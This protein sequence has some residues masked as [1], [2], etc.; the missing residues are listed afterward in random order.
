MKTLISEIAARCE[1]RHNC[2]MAGNKEW[3][4]K[5]EAILKNLAEYLPH[6]SGFDSGTKID[7]DGSGA[8]KVILETSFHHMDENGMYSG[9]TEHVVTVR[10][11]LAHGFSLKIGGRDRNDIKDYIAQCLNDCLESDLWFVDREFTKL[12]EAR[13]EFALSSTWDKDGCRQTW[14][15]KGQAF[16]T[17]ESAK[18]WAIAQ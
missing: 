15:C 1:Q 2:I 12:C 5:S 9:W 7:M 3:Q 16:E 4:E 14:H 11:S 10:G 17:W 13:P 8:D 18:R 6:G